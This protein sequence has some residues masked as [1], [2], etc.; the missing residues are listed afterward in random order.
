MALDHR[1]LVRPG[2]KNQAEFSAFDKF[3]LQGL[4]NKF[5]CV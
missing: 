3:T 1:R 5:G 4:A 2:K